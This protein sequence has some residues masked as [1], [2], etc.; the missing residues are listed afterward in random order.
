MGAYLS[1][2][3]IASRLAALFA[4]VAALMA[5]IGG[6]GWM[7]LRTADASLETVLADRVVPLGDLKTIS[8]H[9]AV[10]QAQQTQK[11]VRG[12]AHAAEK[13][14]EIVDL[15]NSV[16]AQ[17]NLLA[18]N[19]TIEAARAGDAGRGFAVVA[20]E[21]KALA[22]Q[23]GKATDDI[24]AQISSVRAEIETTVKA[25]EA[26]VET[27][28]ALNQ[29]AAA[30]AAAVEEQDAATQEIARNVEQAAAGTQEVSANIGGV[31][32]AADETGS[33]AGQVLQ[34][35]AELQRQSDDMRHLVDGFI[36]RV[37]AA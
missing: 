30:T 14:G 32:Q 5:V 11:T 16:A 34:A 33:A 24:A 19:A 36:A 10:D 8:D 25:I 27:I 9:Y 12:L 6:S 17:T 3:S 31:T 28:S 21:V 29:I 13:I 20:S 22:G 4:M 23:T 35:A 1:S 15:I 18:L 2:L 26:I 37:R 7:A